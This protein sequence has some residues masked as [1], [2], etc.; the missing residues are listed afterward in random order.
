VQT[1]GKACISDHCFFEEKGVPCFYIYTLGGSQAYHDLSDTS[2]NLTL[3][4]FPDYFRLMVQF[5]STF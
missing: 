3:I 5:F 1:R 4:E 2:E